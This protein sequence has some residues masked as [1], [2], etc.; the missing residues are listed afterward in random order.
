MANFLERAARIA[1]N[2]LAGQDA[3]F[4]VQMRLD[5]RTREVSATGFDSQVLPED[6]WLTM[7]V[8]MRPIIFLEN[9]PVSVKNLTTQIEREHVLLR[10][11]LRSARSGLAAWKRHA[12]VYAGNLGGTPPSMASGDVRRQ[13]VKIGP[14]GA[15]PSGVPVEGLATDYDYANTYLNAMVW[16]SDTD[17]SIEYQDAAEYMK[18][19][20]RKCAE[21]RVL[22]AAKD[23]IPPLRRWILDARS[24]GH[25][26]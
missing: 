17:K 26:F 24:D 18:Q 5:L 14:P 16:H 23:I 1:N 2:P 15:S 12:F 19:H 13:M 4:S 10:G 3:Q 22:S 6:D 11:Q 7:A 9:D 21:I 8:R 20:Y 25:D